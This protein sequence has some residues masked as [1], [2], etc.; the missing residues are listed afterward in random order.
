MKALHSNW[1][2]ALV[3][4]MA[5][6]TAAG[7]YIFPYIAAPPMDA[8]ALQEIMDEY[9]ALDVRAAN[10]PPADREALHALLTEMK[11][12][13]DAYGE[14]E[15][16]QPSCDDP[17]TRSD[18]DRAELAAVIAYDERIMPLFAGDFAYVYHERLFLSPETLEKYKEPSEDDLALALCGKWVRA[19]TEQARLQAQ[20]GDIDGALKRLSALD[21]LIYGLSDSTAMAPLMFSVAMKTVVEDT[22]IFLAPLLPQSYLETTIAEK[23]FVNRIADDLLDAIAVTNPL[24]IKINHEISLDNAKRAGNVFSRRFY[25]HVAPIYLKRE[26]RVHAYLIARIIDGYRRWLAAGA[27]EPPTVAV[28]ELTAFMNDYKA[29]LALI[30]IPNFDALMEQAWRSERHYRCMLKVFEAEYTRRENAGATTTVSCDNGETVKLDHLR[31][32]FIG[33]SKTEA[34]P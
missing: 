17:P 19:Q 27:T 16:R 26:M 1:F 6:L 8:P 23:P 14:L 18:E 15:Y 13:L 12:A 24:M 25:Q 33:E 20:S 30:A 4:I 32:C 10:T 34:T 31:G 5:T 29:T 28:D 21:D 3:M 2:V 7:Y 11:P 22:F 9:Y